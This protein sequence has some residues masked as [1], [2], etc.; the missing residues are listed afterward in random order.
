MRAGDFYRRHFQRLLVPYYI[1]MI[2]LAVVW[3]GLAVI[4][5]GHENHA[6]STEFLYGAK[7]GNQPFMVDTGQILNAIFILPRMYFIPLASAWF[8]ALLIQLYLL[9]PLLIRLMDRFGRTKFWWSCL[10]VTIFFTTL[11]MYAPVAPWV[12]PTYI[13][14]LARLS[15]FALG[16]VI[17]WRLSTIK[18]SRWWRWWPV[19]LIVWSGGT[20]Y[21]AGTLYPVAPL[22]IGLGAV[23]MAIPVAGA[24]R[25]FSWLR[26]IGRRSLEV[27]LIHDLVRFAYGSW[28]IADSW[29]TQWP[30][31]FIF[32][33]GAII[34]L[35]LGLIKI[36]DALIRRLNSH[37]SQTTA[38]HVPPLHS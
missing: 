22:L 10:G 30:F 13:F 14:G 19:A 9:F 15:E 36:D 18:P 23:T 12:P 27:F 17:G 25:N 32:Y 38:A 29:L 35:S 4:R 31:G 20:Y 21:S 37:P 5:A 16:M 26:W 34:V 8:V 2:G 33:F 24:L 6:I 1:S 11:F 28:P 3:L 7:L